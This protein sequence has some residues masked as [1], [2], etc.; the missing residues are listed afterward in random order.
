MASDK[1]RAQVAT[2][3]QRRVAELLINEINDPRAGFITITRVEVSKDLQVATIYWSV[4]GEGGVRSRVAGMLDHMN[5]F[6]RTAVG[7]V[8]KTR[9]VP[10]VRFEYD[11][12][13]DKAERIDQI[14]R[15]VRDEDA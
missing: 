3:I 6:V 1:S 12:S 4:L 2:R 8:L 5:G 14:L 9:T 7:R 15:E 13:L 11:D 10:E